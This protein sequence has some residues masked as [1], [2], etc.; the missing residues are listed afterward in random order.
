[1]EPHPDDPILVEPSDWAKIFPLYYRIL[2]LGCF[3]VWCWCLNLHGLR[4]AGI[5]ARTILQGSTGPDDNFDCSACPPE[6]APSSLERSRTATE[7]LPAHVP[8]CHR[9]IHAESELYR[10]ALILTFVVFFSWWCYL[11]V[12]EDIPNVKRFIILATGIVL[13]GILTLPFHILAYAD[14]MRFFRALGRVLYPSLTAPVFFCDVI[15]ADILTSFARVFSDSWASLCDLSALLLPGSGGDP[16]TPDRIN[17]SFEQCG[18][19][20]F[21]PLVICLPYLLRFRQCINEALSSPAG[22]VR[23]RHL[24]NAAKYAS[25]FPVVLLSGYEKYLSWKTKD[26]DGDGTI[27][28]RDHILTLLSQLWLLSAIVNTLYSIYWDTAVDWNLG[29]TARGCLQSLLNRDAPNLYYA[30]I[31]LSPGSPAPHLVDTTGA[32]SQSRAPYNHSSPMAKLSS[33]K[34]YP[35]SLAS[36]THGPCT[37]SFGL[38]QDAGDDALLQASSLPTPT[39][40]TLTIVTSSHPT[41]PVDNPVGLNLPPVSPSYST[42]STETDH[43]AGSGELIV[44][45]SPRPTDGLPPPMAH[46]RAP[47]ASHHEPRTPL[48]RPPSSAPISPTGPRSDHPSVRS[49]S[50]SPRS[51]DDWTYDDPTS[52]LNTDSRTHCHPFLRPHIIFDNAL[53][54]AAIAINVLLRTTWTLKI[55]PHLPIET[56]PLG[57]FTLEWLEVLRRWL[58]VYFRVER[59]WLDKKVPLTASTD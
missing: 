52:L 9:A 30:K 45:I 39:G 38:G 36:P 32:L 18:Y 23:R 10:L 58:W 28:P 26:H 6:A 25:S 57:G 16:Q 46:L 27:T 47:N 12:P 49:P 37:S 48:L 59:E 44:N 56:L 21:G 1:M 3:G 41:D 24:A 50:S 34:T 33:R 4:I 14:R 7:G 8:K 51:S 53:Y 29:Y 2:L 54:Y 22:P 55:S 13:I 15:M 5:D 11:L 17:F 42:S 20:V 40:S 31:V 19:S 35:A 43:T